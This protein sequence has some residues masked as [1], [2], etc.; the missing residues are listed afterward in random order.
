MGTCHINGGQVNLAH[1]G[2]GS[3]A[4]L[5]T[6]PP[7]HTKLAKMKKEEIKK[8]LLSLEMKNEFISILSCS[9]LLYCI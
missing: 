5:N 9:F 2:K 8:E 4:A 6:S 3:I 1:G 7:P